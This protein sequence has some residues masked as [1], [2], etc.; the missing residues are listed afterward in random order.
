MSGKTG[1]KTSTDG[2]R[3]HLAVAGAEPTDRSAEPGNRATAQWD[4]AFTARI[5]E[6][7]KPL[8]ERYFR[9]EVRGMEHMPAG[10]ALVVSNHSGGALTPDV[11]VF[12]SGFYDKFGYDRPVFTLA[13]DQV[14]VGPFADW[15]P[16]AG[17]IPATRESAAEALRSNGVV[18][19]FPGGDFDSYRPTSA[20]N[21]VDFNGR[22][23]Y[24]RTA[25]EA[26]A[27]IVPVVSIGAQEGQLFLT[28]G[29]GLAKRLGLTRL[30]V[31]ILPISVGFPFGASVLILPPNL[32]LPTKVVTQ[33]LKPIHV[34]RKFG[35]NADVAEVDAYVRDV[36]QSAL[37]EL[38]KQRRFP[39]IG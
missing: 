16:R 39:I 31:K 1:V 15:L 17:V 12:C 35:K 32:P 13:H 34:G 22:T 2:G 19:V 37:D 14:Y 9:S 30:R 38:A 36:M 3:R 21:T 18:L 20:R 28:R 6:K 25:I 24:V 29:E 27:P 5:K 26:R 33:V 4:P 23:G 7:V 10:K 8:V 11:L